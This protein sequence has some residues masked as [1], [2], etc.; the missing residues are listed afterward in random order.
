[1]R[2]YACAAN[3]M[4]AIWIRGQRITMCAVTG[5]RPLNV[6][7]SIA[8]EDCLNRKDTNMPKQNA[9]DAAMARRIA[10]LQSLMRKLEESSEGSSELDA[11]FANV[12]PSAPT[13]ATRSMEAL[14]GL[15]AIELPGWLVLCSHSILATDVALYP[16][17]LASFD[18]ISASGRKIDV[19][20][21]CWKI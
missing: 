5:R 12:F 16:L 7:T 6:C 9:S 18:A 10:A 1:P 15:I 3:W 19:D 2:Q 11:E 4:Y 8:V 14:M 13:N 20:T 17:A 21:G